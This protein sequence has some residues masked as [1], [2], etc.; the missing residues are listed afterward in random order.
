V[1]F[2]CLRILEEPLL[3]GVLPADMLYREPYAIEVIATENA[4]K[5]LIDLW[6]YGEVNYLLALGLEPQAAFVTVER[7]VTGGNSMKCASTV[8]FVRSNL[9][10]HTGQSVVDQLLLAQ[11]T[12]ASLEVGAG[13]RLL[14]WVGLV[15]AVHFI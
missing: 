15:C 2:Y 14:A 3:A 5:F 13:L 7:E 1:P 11:V 10:S 4:V 8:E 9:C 6:H 12:G